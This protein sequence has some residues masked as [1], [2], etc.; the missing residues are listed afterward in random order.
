MKSVSVIRKDLFQKKYY[1]LIFTVSLSALLLEFTLTRV[2]SVTLWYHFAFL[3]ISVAMLGL[4]ISGIVLALFRKILNTESEKILPFLSLLYGI[5]I[6]LSFWMINKIPFDPFSLLFE[7]IQ[8]LYLPLYYILIT[9]PFFF[10]G[11]IISYLLAKFKNEIHKLYFFD[12]LGA[13]ISCFFFTVFIPLLGGNGTVAIASAIAFLVTIFSAEKLSKNRKIGIV[14]LG[15][16]AML[17]LNIIIIF[18]IDSSLPVNPTP[19][20]IYANYIKQNPNL[21]LFSGWNTISKIDVM[22]EQEDSPDGYNVLLAVIDEG[23]ATTTI[24]NVKS[25]PPQNKP[26]DLSNLA[27]ISENKPEKVFIIGSAGGGEVLT[28]LHHGAHKVKGVE[29]NG[30]INDLISEKFAYWTGPLIKNNKD[31]EIITDDAR[32]VIRR[33][34][35]NY[36]VIISAH[37]ISS[38][39]VSNGSMSMVENYILT[40]EAVTEYINHLSNNGILYVS[41]PETQLPKLTATLKEV[42]K[43]ILPGPETGSTTINFDKCIAVFRR[44]V[45]VFETEKS[46]LSGI[47]YKKSGLTESEM[48]NL[49]NEIGSLGLEILYD[50]IIKQ[51]GIYKD[52]VELED[53]NQII[54]SYPYSINPA[55]DNKPFFDESVGFRNI[56]LEQI[57]EIFSQNEKGI[58]A[59]KERPIAEVTLIIIFIQTVIIAGVL[60][61][62]PLRFIKKE[63]NYRKS[64]VNIL[65]FASIGLGYIMVQIALIQKFTLLL[66]QPVYTML[67][68]ISAMLIASG[69][70]SISSKK[71][72]G[73]NKSRILMVFMLIVFL[74]VMTGLLTPVLFNSFVRFHIIWRIILTVIIVFPIGFFMGMPFPT[75]LSLYKEEQKRQIAYAWAVNG[76]F[77]VAG[78]VLTMI[79]AMTI[80]FKAVFII[81]GMLYIFA[82][83]IILKKND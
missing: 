47:I 15:G 61:L 65:Y 71:I 43:D 28:A 16:F 35:Q 66:G 13:G 49:Y 29:I 23:N 55:T 70:G 7:K 42:H 31:V 64:P 60:L 26:A 46:F 32:S 9:L 59:L 11:L 78:T 79:L 24:P 68:V 83:F 48:N 82:M 19:N 51:D 3:V 52:I 53:I 56:S 73:E 75:A 2:L 5:S 67:A 54:A 69:L 40:K 4:G 18:N 30:L 25:L 33:D 74:V 1:I 50:P 8:I 80:G 39:A 17:I 45:N 20:K 76:F 63:K 41:R 21:N 58:L 57:K 81:P 37:T 22:R 12:L 36:D 62:I 38:S 44:P 10:A 34:T 14:R 72:I 77:S 6:L 27:F